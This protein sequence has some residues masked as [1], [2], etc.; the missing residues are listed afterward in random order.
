MREIESQPQPHSHRSPLLRLFRRLL[1]PGTSP[2]TDTEEKLRAA[3]AKYRTLVEQL[4][5]VTYIDALTPTATSLYASPQAERLLGYGLDEWLADPEFFAKIL[6]PD[7]RDRV[8]AVVEKCN[9]TG[10]PFHAEYRLVARDGRT[11]WVQDE[12]LIVFD[13]A[14]RPLFTQGY[15]LDITGRKESEQ[16]LAAEH[17]VARV[18]GEATDLEEAAQRLLEVVCTAFGWEAGELWLLDR[19][20][21]VLRRVRMH[22]GGSPALCDELACRR[23][24]GLA[25][26]VWDRLEPVWR[27]HGGRP[28]HGVPIVFGR[29]LLGV[30][31][32]ESQELSEPDE[33]L[34]RTTAV[35]AGQVAQFIERKQAETELWHQA[36]HD[37]LTGL[38]NRT[39]F[40]D[41]VGQALSMAQRAGAP[42]AVML[43]DLDRFKDVNDTLGHHSGDALLSEL[44]RR[45]QNCVRSSDTVS[46]LGGDEFGFLLT[47]VSATEAVELVDRIH[48]ALDEPFGLEELALRVGASFGVALFPDHGDSV[49]ALLRRADVA[50]YVAKRGGSGFAFYDSSEDEHTLTRL[51]MVGELRRALDE[52]E[53]V[54]Y[55]QP[56]VRL[57]SGAVTGVEALLR[58]N[59]PVHGLVLPD[60]FVPVAE[61]AGLMKALTRYVLEEALRQ[62]REWSRAGHVLDVAV[63]VSMSNLLDTAFPADIAALFERWEVPAASLELEITEHSVVGDRF[64]AG[65]VL[66]RLSEMGIRLAID[67]FGTG[68]SSLAYLRRL[69]LQKIK[70]DRSFVA[71]MTTDRDDAVIVRSTIDLAR[72]LGLHSVAEGVESREIYDALLELGCDAAQGDYIS[73]P[74]PAAAFESWL[75]RADRDWCRGDMPTAEQGGR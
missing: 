55:Y 33:R 50:M 43:M 41:R 69:P 19:T 44:G 45:L 48:K 70:I 11:V 39:L 3:E 26:E 24:E 17:G 30:F 31:V 9:R 2:R 74:L 1:R 21:N 57:D 22:E 54:L 52:S 73:C 68:Y 49:E 32:F 4:P 60:T 40:R 47:D 61:R 67:D 8:L 20:K 75:H 34:T 72:N 27:S 29:E 35:I 38:P 53:L 18:L 59:H 23:G 58:W 10:Q 56:Q 16:R 25:G 28:A 51:A 5:L 7:D 42:L 36:L 62:R 65:A 6:H 15:L 63:N 13:D 12:S 71:S 37:G 46:R 66:E 14:G 64:R